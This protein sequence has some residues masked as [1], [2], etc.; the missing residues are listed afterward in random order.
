[1]VVGEGT[2]LFVSPTEPVQGEQIIPYAKKTWQNNLIIAIAFISIRSHNVS[3]NLTPLRLLSIS[4]QHIILAPFLHYTCNTPIG[5]HLLNISTRYVCI[6][7]ITRRVQ[8]PVTNKSP[9]RASLISL[10]LMIYIHPTG[11][12]KAI[13]RAAISRPSGKQFRSQ[14][15]ESERS[16]TPPRL[17]K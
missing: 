5:K 2:I 14:G 4:R 10:H 1:M 3:D 6:V 8:R 7:M 17:P 12:A 13:T 15:S 9:L 16:L 11:H